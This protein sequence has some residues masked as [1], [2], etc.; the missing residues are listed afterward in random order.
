MGPLNSVIT[1][2]E[3]GNST[4]LSSF[5][6]S[7]I[8]MPRHPAAACGLALLPR[9]RTPVP[10]HR[11]SPRACSPQEGSEIATKRLMQGVQSPTE[12]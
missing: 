5:R 7:C 8:A 10:G 11:W 9:Y 12:T 2:L 3:H 1:G 4:Y 6:K